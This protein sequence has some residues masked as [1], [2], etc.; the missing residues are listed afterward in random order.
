LRFPALDGV[1]SGPAVADD[2]AFEVEEATAEA[3]QGSMASG[4]F[5]LTL[6]TGSLWRSSMRRVID[7]RRRWSAKWA[8]EDSNLRPLACKASALPLS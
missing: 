1:G 4:S 8:L 5:K 6:S 3:L 7:V 2:A